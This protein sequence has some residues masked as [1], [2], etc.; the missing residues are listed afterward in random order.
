L[1]YSIAE[2]PTRRACDLSVRG[3]VEND[4]GDLL[5]VGRETR[6]AA[7]DWPGVAIDGASAAS[8]ATGVM[9]LSRALM[10]AGDSVTPM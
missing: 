9:G 10:L 6:T 8:S 2:S 7:H 3:L 4:D 5:N 1:H